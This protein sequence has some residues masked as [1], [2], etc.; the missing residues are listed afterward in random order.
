MGRLK[1]TFIPHHDNN[2]MPDLWQRSAMLLMGGL[3]IVSFTTSNLLSLFWQQS[4]WLVGAVLP[5]VVVEETNSERHAATLPVLVRNEV[6]DRA[7]TLKAEHMAS[8][9]YFAHYS[10]SGVSPWHWFNEAGYPFVHAGENLAV[11]FT[12]SNTVVDAWMNSPTHR[13]NIV[14][15]NYQ[16]IGV[17]TAKGRFEGHD[18]VFVVQLFG[19]RAASSESLPAIEVSTVTVPDQVVPAPRPDTIALE[20]SDETVAG[21]STDSESE[22]GDLVLAQREV[23]EVL[24]PIPVYAEPVLTPMVQTDSTMTLVSDTISTSTTLTRATDVL[25]PTKE[26]FLVKVAAFMTSPTSLLQKI[27]LLVGL[28]VIVGLGISVVVEWRHKRTLQVLYGVGLLVLMCALF[29]IHVLVSQTP[30]IF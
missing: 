22:A 4:A 9:G 20:L 5:A 14:N 12:D 13:A 7:A 28:V 17:G 24:T 30:V 10:P 6:L 8:E 16:E 23:V 15:G 26:P 21:V 29:L 25:I 18:T 2:Y 3:V 11:H 27:Y 19:T 1:R